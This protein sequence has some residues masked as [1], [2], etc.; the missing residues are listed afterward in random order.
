MT[1]ATN[2]ITARAATHSAALP[3]NGVQLI[4]VISGPETGRA[5]LR[6]P[7]GTIVV[8]VKDQPTSLGRLV[9]VGDGYALFDTGDALRRLTL[10]A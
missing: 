2:D 1:D 5:L 3:P 8:A 10:P 7:D 9:G 4:G 6:D